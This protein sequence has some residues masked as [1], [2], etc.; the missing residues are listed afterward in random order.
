MSKYDRF[1]Q[2][3]ERLLQKSSKNKVQWIEVPKGVAKHIIKKYA[4]V[5]ANQSQIE[6]THSK[7]FQ[8]KFGPDLS[9]PD[10]KP[11]SFTPT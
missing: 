11:S 1:H 2:L 6:L 10:A 9:S 8:T 5:F 3:L 7:Q 4:V